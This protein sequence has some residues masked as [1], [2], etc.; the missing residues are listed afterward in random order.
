MK[1]TYTQDHPTFPGRE[2]NA[3]WD[4]YEAFHRHVGL[5]NLTATVFDTG[6]IL[7]T[8]YE[9]IPGQRRVYAEVGVTLWGTTDN[10]PD[11]TFTQPDGTPVKNAWLGTGGIQYLLIDHATGR[12]VRTKNYVGPYRQEDRSA[13]SG[14]DHIPTR[15]HTE[16][17][18]TYWPGSERAPIGAQSIRIDVPLPITP[19]QQEH[20]TTLTRACQAW[21][22]LHPDVTHVGGGVRYHEGGGITGHVW[23]RHSTR[24]PRAEALTWT[25]ATMDWRDRAR[26]L[27]RGVIADTTSVLVPYLIATPVVSL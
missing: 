7:L 16:R 17:W 22:T 27:L 19:E 14:P 11:W 21:A 25:F 23:K 10:R 9:P 8:G 18:A 5:G 1:L 15:F 20:L 2:W 3:T 12:A 6:E 4:T 24:V 13:Y 26:L